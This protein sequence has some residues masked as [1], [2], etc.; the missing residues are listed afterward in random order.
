M[1]NSLLMSNDVRSFWSD[2]LDSIEKFFMERIKDS[3]YPQKI[4][5]LSLGTTN[6]LQ[7]L[8]RTEKKFVFTVLS[9]VNRV[10]NS[11]QKRVVL[12]FDID[13][14]IGVSKVPEIEPTMFRPSVIPLI[15]LLSKYC[16]V[17]LLSNRLALNRCD[18]HDIHDL[19]DSMMIF[20][21][22]DASVI[23]NNE[24][25]KIKEDLL[26]KEK[27]SLM[28]TSNLNK[29]VRLEVLN[30]AH[31]NCFFVAIDDLPY[32]DKIGMHGIYIGQYLQC[33]L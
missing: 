27:L 19:L 15:K 18:L 17:G 12:L 7:K 5:A 33:Y 4:L 28:D 21:S 6:K 8:I 29:L 1:K 3:N 9:K 31:E 20:S 22:R 26:R 24:A 11:T 16:T 10:L 14:T 2:N 25:I 32:A 23:Y 30:Q 13:D